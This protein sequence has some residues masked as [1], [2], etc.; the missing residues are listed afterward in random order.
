MILLRDLS[1]GRRITT[2]TAK[3]PAA[4]RLIR[5]R[6]IALSIAKSHFAHSK[7]ELDM[8]NVATAMQCLKFCAHLFDLPLTDQ[9]HNITELAKAVGQITDRLWA[10]GV[11]VEVAHGPPSSE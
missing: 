3:I 5:H 4:I 1:C 8:I 10:F 7:T 9:L 6:D 2:P 11:A